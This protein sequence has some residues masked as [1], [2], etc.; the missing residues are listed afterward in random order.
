MKVEYS[1][2]ALSDLRSIAAYYAGTDYPSVGEKVAARV[3]EVIARL[4]TFPASG[5]PVTRRPGLR[6]VP[7]LTYPYVLFYRIAGPDILRIAHIRHTSRQPWA[8]K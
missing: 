2:R 1:P 4:A 5:R 3:R 6:V 8:G 7:L